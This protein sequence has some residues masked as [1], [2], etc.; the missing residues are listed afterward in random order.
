VTVAGQ[1]ESFWYQTSKQLAPTLTQ[2]AGGQIP[3]EGPIAAPIAARI[4]SAAIK[5]EDE[6]LKQLNAI[7]GD[8]QALRE[9]DYKTGIKHLKTAQRIAGSAENETNARARQE[10]QQECVE[11]VTKA[12]DHFL[13]AQGLAQGRFSEAVIAYYLGICWTILKQKDL[14]RDNFNASYALAKKY[15]AKENKPAA[16]ALRGY[17]LFVPH[18]DAVE[19]VAFYSGK[20][21]GIGVGA[22]TGAV[23]G[24]ATLNV[25]GLAGGGAA[26]WLAGRKYGSAMGKWQ[27]NQVKPSIE[28]QRRD[29]NQKVEPPVRDLMNA[30]KKLQTE[31]PEIQFEFVKPL[32]T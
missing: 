24:A 28:K 17:E 10:K 12:K 19:K 9:T 11:E 1:A 3:A 21:G 7:K 4:L 26:G 16:A 13:K 18:V 27:R 25:F 31:V 15:L 23:L 5:G 6:V 8:T 22:V 20:L 2:L 14:A 30:L 29:F 32:P